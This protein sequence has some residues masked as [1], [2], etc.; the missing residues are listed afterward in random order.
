MRTIIKYMVVAL[1]MLVSCGSPHS[2]KAVSG[3]DS[4]ETV[5]VSPGTVVMV[6]DTASSE[7]NR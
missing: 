5:I 3:A 6:E 2:E 7:G 1:A 4:I